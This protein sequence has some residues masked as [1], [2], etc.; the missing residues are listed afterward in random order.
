MQIMDIVWLMEE[1]QERVTA[2]GKAELAER[3]YNPNGLRFGA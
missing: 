1:R 2:E 3:R